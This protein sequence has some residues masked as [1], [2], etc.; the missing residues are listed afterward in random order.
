MGGVGQGECRWP[1]PSFSVFPLLARRLERDSRVRSAS[2][3]P[4][5]RFAAE[6]GVVFSSSWC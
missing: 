1:L 6:I 4:R 2:V 3:V 5:K